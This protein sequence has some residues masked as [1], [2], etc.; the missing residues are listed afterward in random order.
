MCK[1]A[2]WSVLG[3]LLAG[4]LQVQAA[5]LYRDAS[6]ANGG[7]AVGATELF[8]FGP[9][10]APGSW[11]ITNH[12]VNGNQMAVLTATGETGNGGNGAAVHL[13]YPK[14][15]ATHGPLVAGNVIRFSCWLA[16]DATNP[17]N[18]H[19][20]Q[21]AILKLEFYDTPL[22]NPQDNPEHI[23]FD[24]DQDTDGELTTS[25]A[26]GLSPTEWRQFILEYTVDTN[27]VDLSQLKEVRPVV[28][29][30]DFTGNGFSG[31]VVVDNLRA[32]VFKDQNEAKANPVD[33]TPPGAL[34]V[35]S[36]P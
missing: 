19:D 5:E 2:V 27:H 28:V 6:L 10:G 11:G 9:F 33:T 23:L 21:F 24:S 26:D 25:F 18:R 13:E 8:Q 1:V 14:A 12:T 16:V 34:P 36:S 29:A 3:M 20:W 22:A 4:S 17:I 31:N 7:L 32:E 35:A 15:F 30:G